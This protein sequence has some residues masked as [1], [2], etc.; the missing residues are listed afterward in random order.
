MTPIRRLHSDAPLYITIKVHRT[1][2]EVTM[3]LTERQEQIKGL[4]KQGKSAKQ[5]AKSLKISENA[6]YQQIRRMRKAGENVGT[7]RATGTR[8]S[9]AKKTGRQSARKRPSLE[10]TLPQAPGNIPEP[11]IAARPP[12]PLQ[13]VRN[14][15][16]EI[17]ADIK[18]AET[19]V[20]A[21]QRALDAAKAA[22]AKLKDRHGDELKSLDTAEKALAPKPVNKPQPQ[23][24]SARRQRPSR[25]QSGGKTPEPS[26]EP[27][28]APESAPQASENGQ[29]DAG[30]VPTPEAAPETATA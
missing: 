6:V 7:K 3:A 12:T 23:P 20:T 4:L 1:E 8:A 17:H 2:E 19:E 9:A 22:H 26:P 13:S 16:A 15:R 18:L 21:A 14:R 29:G 5:I 11:P 25:A 24:A 30:Q 27:P 28:A 10:P